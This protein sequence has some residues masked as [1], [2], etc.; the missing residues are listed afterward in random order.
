M[1]SNLKIDHPFEVKPPRLKENSKSG[2]HWVRFILIAFV[3]KHSKSETNFCW[4]T[5]SLLCTEN[6]CEGFER[7]TDWCHQGFQGRWFNLQTNC[8][9]D[10]GFENSYQ[11]WKGKMAS[12]DDQENYR[13]NVTGKTRVPGTFWRYISS[14]KWRYNGCNLM[15]LGKEYVFI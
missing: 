4:N 15:Y 5:L 12:D 11:K 3:F 9:K 7:D 10:D 8:K 2:Y 6:L 13:F 1:N 14:F